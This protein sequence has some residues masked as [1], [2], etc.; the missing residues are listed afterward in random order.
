[1]DALNNVRNLVL[2]HL[3]TSKEAIAMSAEVKDESCQPVEDGCKNPRKSEWGNP[4]GHT[5]M[6]CYARYL[7]FTE[8][9]YKHMSYEEWKLV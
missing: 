1:M 4:N 2:H 3:I 5:S 6:N 9:G 8:P 7:E